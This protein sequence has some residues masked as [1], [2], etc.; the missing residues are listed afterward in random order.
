MHFEAMGQ[1]LQSLSPFDQYSWDKNFA[2]VQLLNEFNWVHCH[3]NE[4]LSA[5]LQKDTESWGAFWEK[6]NALE[7][8][9][10]NSD[11]FKD[12]VDCTIE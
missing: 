8:M 1:A 10:Y 12:E 5:L 9:D 7:I 2:V 3:E 6:E 11:L 4:E